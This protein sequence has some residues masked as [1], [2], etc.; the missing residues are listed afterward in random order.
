[1]ERF[2]TPIVVKNYSHSA[3][4]TKQSNLTRSGKTDKKNEFESSGSFQVAVN[5][6][7]IRIHKSLHFKFIEQK[8]NLQIDQTITCELT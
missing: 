1:M 3:G 2:G 4:S 6:A 8:T 5:G 7:A